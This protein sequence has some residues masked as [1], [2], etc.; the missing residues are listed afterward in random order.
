[1][2]PVPP[3][4]A[5]KFLRW[6]CRE[7][8]LEEVE[9]DL[10]EVFEV[11]FVRSPQKAKKQFIWSVIKHF[12][13][14]FIRTVN[15]GQ[16]SNLTTMFKYDLRIAWRHLLKQKVY[17]SIKIGGFALGIAA[18]VLIALFVKD[19]LSYDQHFEAKD[20]VYRVVNQFKGEGELERWAWFPA[21]TAKALATDFPEI[22]QAGRL[23][24]TQL[25]GA[26]VNEIKL[27]DK[28][29]IFHEN[30]FAYIDP[31][32]IDILEI[33]LLQGN[34]PKALS[35]PNTLLISEEKARKYF[36]NEDPI[37]K[38]I[39]L[40]GNVLD[41]TSDRTYTITGVVETKEASHFRYDFFMTLTGVEFYPGEQDNW[42]ANNYHTYIKVSPK[43]NPQDLENKLDALTK[44]YYIPAWTAAGD[45]GIEENAEKSSYHLQ[46]VSDIYLR[47]GNIRDNLNH[48]DIRFVW[49]FA[50]VAGF[51]LLIATIN[52]INLSTA[53]SA[54][55]AVEVGLRKTVGSN[56]ERLIYQF[57]TESLVFS[58]LSFSL[59]LVLALLLLPFFNNLSEKT[60]VLPWFEWWFLPLLFSTCLALSVLTGLYPALYLSSF[61]PINTLKGNLSRGS[62]SSGLRSG[63]VIFQFT[64]S[65][66]LIIATFVI[67]RQMSFM[68]NKNLGFDK[69]QVVMIQGTNTLGEQLPT[70]KNELLELS[71][72]KHV[73][74]SN[75]LPVEGAMRDNNG[76]YKEG[77]RGQ[78]NPVYGQIWS[79]D[80]DYIKTLGIK[81]VAGRDFNEHMASDRSSIIIN[82][83]MVSEFGFEDPIGQSIETFNNPRTI[84]GVIEDFHFESM[85][86]SIRP[87][88][89]VIAP[90]SATTSVKIQSDDIA[91]VL[92]AIEKKWK[93]FSPHQEI[94]YSFLDDSFA[95][96]HEDVQ[97]M[98]KIFTSFTILAIIVACLGLFALSAFMVEQRTKEISIRLVLGASLNHVFRLLTFNFVRLVLISIVIAAPVS[99]YL[100]EQW[101]A[102][103][104]YRTKLGIDVFLFS[105]VL[106]IIISLL[107]ISYQSIR[108]GLASPVN[109]LK[110]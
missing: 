3:N 82:Q 70:F 6:F 93:K 36:S 11:Q 22:E 1:M 75:Y 4:N 76:F 23:L 35:N 25:F 77:T 19:E 73:S 69:E 105:S 58:L 59:A 66:A 20:Q 102:D 16:N 55:R 104:T 49:L 68:L 109:S 110:S 85:K 14:E 24:N 40:Q 99:W 34:G 7:D 100:M 89:L 51:I 90:S 8:Y 98:A 21:P 47:N 91:G 92:T 28:P 2:R 103:Y 107:T 80:A 53:K 87:L 97:Q 30:G 67:H 108:A 60:L 37:G 33:K 95:L 48:G 27:N 31:G 84:I 62:K 71:S 54:N 63:L 9:G 61:K 83:K 56:R 78:E 18:C 5:L 39:T 44:N 46:P 17:S 43:T 72:V 81:L 52:F 12:R 79:V 41:N 32:M 15:I 86:D 74:V 88:S 26:G 10:V 13:P 96:M 57:L 42:N 29:Q 50:V 45:Q 64:T 65:V 38:T 101:L 106:V 94:R